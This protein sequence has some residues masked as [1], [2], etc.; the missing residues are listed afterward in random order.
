MKEEITK[1]EFD[2]LKKMVKNID[3][4]LQEVYNLIVA[5]AGDKVNHI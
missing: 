1:Q 3:Q 4:K 2:E 5:L